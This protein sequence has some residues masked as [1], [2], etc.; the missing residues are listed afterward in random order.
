MKQFFIIVGVL[1]SM[2]CCLIIGVYLL[3]A[4]VV[5]GRWVV[6]DIED[7]KPIIQTR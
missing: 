2:L 5:V 6:E 4:V 1:L 7:G 3:V